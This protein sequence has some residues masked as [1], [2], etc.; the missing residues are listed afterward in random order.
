GL[1]LALVA[2][3]PIPCC[4]IPQDV[5]TR[6][7]ELRNSLPTRHG[8]AS[9]IIGSYM[10]RSYQG[11]GVIEPMRHAAGSIAPTRWR[12]SVSQ[13]GPQACRDHDADSTRRR[14]RVGTR[15]R[16]RPSRRLTRMVHTFFSPRSSGVKTTHARSPAYRRESPGTFS[17]TSTSS[18]LYS[19]SK[20]YAIAFPRGGLRAT[21][22]DAHRAAATSTMLD[23]H[24]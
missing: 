13:A 20:P 7:G 21:G 17:M 9:R 15:Q 23:R 3:D 2:T 14:L 18:P 12:P 5:F 19:R 16:R 8:G 24:G 4:D 10:G 1:C 22:A 11:L 6:H